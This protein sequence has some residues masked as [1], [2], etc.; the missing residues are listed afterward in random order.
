MILPRFESDQSQRHHFK[1]AENRAQRN[2]CRR[3]ARKV[4]MVE[5]AND[6]ARKK[7][8][9]REQRR[10]RSRPNLN[11]LQP[12]KQEADHH[13]GKY[14]KEA[15]HPKV[16][17]PPAPVLR[18]HQVAA[19]PIHQTRRVEQRNRDARNQKQ[20]QQ[21]AVFALL[22]QRWLQ[23]SPHQPSHSTSPTSSRICQNLPRSTYS[24]PWLPNQNH[25]L[26]RRC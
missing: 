20:D 6:S 18:R 12:R 1:C 8:R 22:H 19:L 24:Y 15:F 7:N 23:R 5:R 14:F 3:R 10:P 21:R 9:R 2:H 25:M 13:R 26:P 4:K 17:H 16:N 11:Q